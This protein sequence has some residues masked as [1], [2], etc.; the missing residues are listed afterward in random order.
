MSY[1]EKQIVAGNEY[2]TPYLY[3]VAHLRELVKENKI[4]E[5]KQF[6]KENDLIVKNHK[7]MSKYDDMIQKQSGFWKLW[8]QCRKIG[9]NSSYGMLLSSSAVWYDVDQGRSITLTGQNITKHMTSF[10]IQ[11]MIGDYDYLNDGVCIGDTDSIIFNSI[12]DTNE[13][14]MTIEELFNNGTNLVIDKEKEYK[15]SELLVKA[16]DEEK[17]EAEY[18]PIEWIYRHKVNKDCYQI[19][20]EEGNIIECTSDHSIM[21]ERNG[22]L[23]EVKPEEIL[24]DDLLIVDK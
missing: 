18:L 8:Q 6:M 22:K 9:L 17:Q 23:I 10:G 1:K 7:I 24:E 15:F 2:N 20:D 12:I 16:Y 3:D 13:G 14:K 5:I 19:E 4:E 21:V 11:E